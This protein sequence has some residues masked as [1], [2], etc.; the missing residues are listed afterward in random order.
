MS[1]GAQGVDRGQVAINPTE[2]DEPRLLRPFIVSG[3]SAGALPALDGI[4]AIAVVL[5]VIFHSYILS[6]APITFLNTPF[7]GRKIDLTPYLSTGFVAVDLF[8]VLSGF[9]LS[10]YWLRADFLGRPRPSTAV[11]ARRRIFRIVPAYYCCLLFMLL[12]LCPFVIDPEFVW[13]GLGLRMLLAHLLFVQHLF[14]ITSGSYNANGALWT[15][16]IEAMFYVL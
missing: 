2:S 9:L 15:L 8:F 3:S 11:Y 6:G 10:Q 14:P 1:R 5:V 13:S 4:R 12:L 7:N 16:T